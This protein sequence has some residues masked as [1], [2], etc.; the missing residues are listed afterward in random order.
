M[1]SVQELADKVGV[2]RQTVYS[3]IKKGCPHH[4]KERGLREDIELDFNAVVHWINDQKKR[5]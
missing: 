1:L 5:S 3:W 4:F 2:T